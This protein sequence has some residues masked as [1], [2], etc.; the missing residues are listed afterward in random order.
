MAL[1]G[2]EAFAAANFAAALGS[3]FFF[4]LDI[5]AFSVAAAG[6]EAG[7]AELDLADTV[8]F[9]AVGGETNRAASVSDGSRCTLSGRVAWGR[10][11]CKCRKQNYRFEEFL[12][13]GCISRG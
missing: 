7:F 3:I 6:L 12:R 4:I 13:Q 8:F 2:S 9:P 11:Y 10:K 1:L 5:A